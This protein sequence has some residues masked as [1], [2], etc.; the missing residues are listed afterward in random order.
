MLI[1]KGTVAYICRDSEKEKFDNG[2]K[3]SSMHFILLLVDENLL[4]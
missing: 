2:N 3:G 1:E 4:D